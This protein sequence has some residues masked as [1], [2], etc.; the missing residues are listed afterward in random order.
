M[1]DT[2]GDNTDQSLYSLELG[3]ISMVLLII[4]CVI[5]CQGI[6]QGSIKLGLDRK[7]ATEQA[8]GTFPLFS[9]QLSFGMLVDIRA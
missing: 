5:R 6:T 9:N 3:G 4:Q 1:H 2:A 7:K 8:S